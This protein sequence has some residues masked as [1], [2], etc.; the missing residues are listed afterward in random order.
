MNLML[1]ALCCALSGSPARG[2]VLIVA[3]DLGARD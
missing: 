2:V 3:D 1:L